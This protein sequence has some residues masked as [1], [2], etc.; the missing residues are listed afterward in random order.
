MEFSKKDILG[1]FLIAISTLV[2]LSLISYSSVDASFNT[3]ASVSNNVVGFLGAYVADIFLQVFGISSFVIPLAFILLSIFLFF[4]TKESN[5]S[6]PRI[7]FSVLLLFTSSIAI[8]AVFK[9]IDYGGAKFFA[10]G[11]I[12]RVFINFLSPYLNR[13]GT[14]II[15]LTLSVLICFYLA[16]YS[17]YSSVLIILS[18]LYKTF[19]VPFIFLFKGILKIYAWFKKDKLNVN[20]KLQ[21]IKAKKIK[22]KNLSFTVKMSKEKKDNKKNK[23]E[24]KPRN[25]GK[26]K[27]PGLDLLD[28]V[29]NTT[30]SQNMNEFKKTASVLQSKLNDFGVKGEV[31]EVC[32]GP[33][34]T[35]YEFR[36]APGIKINKVTN[37]SD[38]L[39]LAL[40]CGSVRV[41]APIPGKSVIGIEVPNKGRQTV[42][43][44]ELIDSKEFKSDSKKIPITIG[45][46][47]EGNPFITD[48]SSMPHLL[49]AGATGSGKSV[50]IN[51][52]ICSIL[53]KFSP[54]EV[55]LL[56]VDP[57]MLELSTYDGIPHLLLPVVTEANKASQALKW[58]LRE[59]NDRYR[60]LSS[61]GC[62]NITSYNK[63]A[64]EKLPYIIIIVDELSDLMMVSSK[65]VE[66]AITRLAQMA[67]AAGIHMV[68]ATQRPSV[69][70]I[71]GLIKANFPARIA[72]KVSSRVDSR[73]I[74]DGI[75]AE[76][77]LGM[78]DLL[79]IPPNVNR[80]ERCHGAFI[81]DGEVK[82]IV[83]F[84][85][86]Q[87]KPNYNEEI[88]KEED[89]NLDLED[90]EYDELYDKAVDV[91]LQN[92]KASISFVQRKLRIGYNRAAR[93]IEI[94]E[95]EGIV[96][97]QYGTGKREVLV[98][99]R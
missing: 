98:D 62:R 31:T 11:I 38:D 88:L 61:K 27:L 90:E 99:N 52:L 51:T 93:I 71:T 84:V 42:F 78:G 63:V 2:F 24:I 49:V 46:N 44:K 36:P 19:I 75:G 8:D 12:G 41:I 47:T 97:E 89:G 17:V 67:R 10:G 77:L 23:L 95:R 79:F 18:F 7:F 76:K 91:V 32:P 45:K 26:Y 74:L 68:L 14:S 39:A 65:D 6:I 28:K 29:S 16:N 73:T 72:F 22:D 64:E 13:I 55:K 92:K 35:M 30:Y 15:F 4:R 21:E 87:E 85:K 1:V 48:L 60:I 33:V 59:M 70:V 69:D 43:L 66:S 94:M 57:K 25:F 53:Y 56:M 3:G 40:G 37:L 80:L 54:S 5:I 96:S 83:D 81:S 86:A 82:N 50:F 58:A 20:L 9:N 34:I